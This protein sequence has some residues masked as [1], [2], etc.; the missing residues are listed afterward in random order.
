MLL[1][2]QISSLT[3]WNQINDERILTGWFRDPELTIPASEDEVD[4]AGDDIY[5]EYGWNT[6]P[7]KFP[8]LAHIEAR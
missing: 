5:T 8:V 6:E 2:R 7:S 3:E 4:A 1:Y